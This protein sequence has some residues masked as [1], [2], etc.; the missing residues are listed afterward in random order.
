MVE[1]VRAMDPGHLITIGLTAQSLPFQER[2]ALERGEWFI[3]TSFSP[4]ELLPWLDF[5]AL[6]LY[7][8]THGEQ[9]NVDLMELVLRGAYHGKPVVI[10]ETFPLAV[11]G[12]P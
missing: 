8:E 3:Y 6:H 4:Y 2:G 10:E 9:S 11:G 1:A 12:L 5:V 7:P